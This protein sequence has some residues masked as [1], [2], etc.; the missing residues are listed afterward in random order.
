MEAVRLWD[1]D[2][3]RGNLLTTIG[4]SPRVAGV[5]RGRGQ[6]LLDIELQPD[7]TTAA[8]ADG[9]GAVT[10]YDMTTHREVG[11]LAREGSF[12]QAPAFSP[13]GGVVAV[14][15][16]LNSCR[17]G[18]FC[19][20]GIDVF[21]AADLQPRNVSYEGFGSV[22]ADLVYSPDG[23]MLAAAPHFAWAPGTE[24]IA[25]WRVDQPDTPVR[26]L[27][28]PNLGVDLRETPDVGAARLARV[29]PRRHAA[30][31]ERRGS[32][33]RF[34]RGDRTADPVV[35][36]PRRDGVE[37]GRPHARHRHS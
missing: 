28:L 29:L 27:T 9:G 37:P 8:V 7:G 18:Q 14:S 13:D 32:D 34:R 2:E 12:I 16:Q 20:T 15:R 23:T 21:G 35:R 10:F 19:E 36:R 5:V 4:R 6:R 25:I 11:V 22:V 3:T 17:F 31:C 30:V 26:R 24:N 33:D 1:S